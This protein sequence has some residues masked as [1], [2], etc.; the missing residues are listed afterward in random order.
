MREFEDIQRLIRLKRFEQPGE[1]FTDEFLKSFHQRQRA[2]MLKQSSVELLWERIATWW[3][4]LL[5]P[6]WGLAVASAC[7]CVMGL[8]IYSH[9]PAAPAV[10]AAPIPV[11]EQD[12]LVPKLDLTDLPM[13]SIANRDDAQLEDT[14]LRKHLEVRP[15]L[16]GSVSALPVSGWH[17]PSLQNAVPA[18]HDDAEGG[19]GR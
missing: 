18:I 10:T 2:E 8:W 16:E 1:G 9:S 17:S 5:V 3:N 15:A 12:L 11:V 13:A 7:V 6:K 4:H 19:L 14:L